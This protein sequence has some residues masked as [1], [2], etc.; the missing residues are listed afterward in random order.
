MPRVRT[1]NARSPDARMSCV[2]RARSP[3]GRSAR[4]VITKAPRIADA[5]PHPRIKSDASRARLHRR[6]AA[7]SC[8]TISSCLPSR[9]RDGRE[10]PPRRRLSSARRDSASSRRAQSPHDS[11][12]RR[13]TRGRSRCCAR[14]SIEWRRSG[15]GP[16]SQANIAR[17]ASVPPISRRA[18]V[19]LEQSS[20]PTS[21]PRVPSRRACRAE[22]SPRA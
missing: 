1:R 15:V 8:S 18:P 5:S 10:V 20:R 2:A 19:P 14:P 6:G 13:R 7:S 3:T 11:K 16:A 22:G 21:G 9:H 4:R 17:S 12:R